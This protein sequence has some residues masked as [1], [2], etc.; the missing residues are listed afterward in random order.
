MKNQLE[1]Q[2]FKEISSCFKKDEKG[3]SFLAGIYV[4]KTFFD[5]SKKDK[6]QK[7]LNKLLKAIEKTTGGSQWSANIT[8]LI[9][10]VESLPANTINKE[11][12]DYI[13]ALLQDLKPKDPV[14]ARLIAQFIILNEYGMSK[15]RLMQKQDL[16]CHADH[17]MRTATKMFNL[18]QQAILTLLKYRSKNTQQVFVTHIN[19]GGQAIIGSNLTSEGG[20][21]N[22]KN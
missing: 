21:G 4:G 7:E 22:P 13:L 14:E 2:S 8:F 3:N 12:F 11:S 1:N 16:M 5:F 6:T 18:S 10:L 20:E 17:F 15:L 19:Q 9:H